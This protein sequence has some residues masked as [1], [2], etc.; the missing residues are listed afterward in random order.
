[1]ADEL[2]PDDLEDLWRDQPVEPHTSSAADMRTK[3]HQLEA[4]TRRGF[5]G[6]AVLMTFG[7]AGYGMFLYFFP[8]LIHRIGAGLT[9]AGYLFCAY[10]I[11][12]RFLLGKEPSRVVSAT[13]SRYRAELGQQRDFCLNAWRT[14][15]LPFVPGPAVFI[16]SFLIPDVGVVKALGLTTVLISS[17]FVFAVPLMRRK[18]R[19]LQ[20]EIDALDTLMRQSR[21]HGV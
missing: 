13:A 7:A 2:G 12:K 3:V 1:M 16:M 6:M 11:Y 15:L 8:S 9:L 21:E 17:P 19:M 10:Q 20:Q 4:N 5:H 18:A 14:Y